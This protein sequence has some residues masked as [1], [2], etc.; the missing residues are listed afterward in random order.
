MGREAGAVKPL[1][2]LLLAL[3]TSTVRPWLPPGLWL[4]SWGEY[5]ERQLPLLGI[6]LLLGLGEN[7]LAAANLGS[8][9]A[10]EHA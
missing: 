9:S 6:V 7:Q 1:C 4:R 5:W 2:L 8:G 10:G 3:L